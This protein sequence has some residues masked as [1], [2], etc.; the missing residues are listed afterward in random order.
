[1]GRWH[2]SGT[3]S[4]VVTRDLDCDYFDGGAEGCTGSWDDDFYTDDYGNI[5]QETTCPVCKTV[6]TYRE[7]QE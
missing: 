3:L 7:E 5:E 1:M 4:T 2:G 6:F